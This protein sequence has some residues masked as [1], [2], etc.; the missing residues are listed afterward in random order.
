MTRLLR[1][2]VSD[3]IVDLGLWVSFFFPSD[4]QPL[5]VAL[6]ENAPIERIEVHIPKPFHYKH[7]GDVEF[8]LPGFIKKISNQKFWTFFELCRELWGDWEWPLL[9]VFV[10]NPDDTGFTA[11]A[12]KKLKYVI[13]STF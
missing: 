12:R 4:V 7:T 2:H 3:R 5:E 10:D 11:E 13:R 8:N 6:R 9:R 1:L